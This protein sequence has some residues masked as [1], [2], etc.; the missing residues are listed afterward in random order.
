[1]EFGIDFEKLYSVLHA[2][3]TS[4]D[5]QHQV[6]PVLETVVKET[7]EILKAKGTLIRFFNP[8]NSQLEL[9]A[10]YG[11]SQQYLSKGPVVSDN[12]ITNICRLN[13]LVIIRN[14]LNYPRL[15]YPHAAWREGIRMLLDAPLKYNNDILGI[16][17][18]FFF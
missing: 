15:Q 1:M 16:I 6:K 3:S 18:I 10:T 12:I 4:I 9:M 7:T 8:Q 5:T 13:R 11:L 14:I 17:R 2:I